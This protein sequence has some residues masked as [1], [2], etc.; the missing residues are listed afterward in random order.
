MRH[1][2]RSNSH[3]SSNRGYGPMK[4]MQEAFAVEVVSNG[5]NVTQAAIAAGYSPK[6]A[7]QIG[8]NL[9]DAN[10][11]PYSIPFL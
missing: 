6:S 3:E 9:L 7:R 8:Q 10:L 5:G 11:N 2:W 4:E 1:E